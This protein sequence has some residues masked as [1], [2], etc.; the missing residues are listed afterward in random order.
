MNTPLYWT[1]GLHHDGSALY[2][3]SQQP[4]LGDRVTIKLRAPASAPIQ[5]VF[6][7]TAPDG[8]NHL[9][10]MHETWRDDHLAWW[11]VEMP[12]VMPANPY[13]FKLLTAEG[14]YFLNQAGVSRADG[15]EWNDFKLLADYASPAWAQ[16]AVFYQIF[17]DR[18]AAGNPANQVP[19]GAWEIRGYKT[20]RRAWGDPVLTWKETGSL[21]YYG[22]DLPGIVQKIPYLVELGVNALYLNPIFVSYSNHRYDVSDFY[23]I[24]PYVGGN[25]GLA[26]LRRATD[27]AGIKIM[28]DVTLNHLGWR[29]PWFTDAQNNPESA[30]AE[31]F[32][33]YERPEKYES[34]LGVR[35]LPKFNYRSEKLREQMYKSVDSVLRT[36]L[37]PPYRID[38]WRLD[39][40]NM[41]ARQGA[42]Q[43]SHKIGRQLRRAV[44]EEAPNTYLIG[45]HFYDATTYLQGDELDATMNYSGF[46]IPLWRWLNGQDLGTDYRPEV[47]D[48]VLM[49]AEAVVEQW[50]R[51]RAPLPWQVARHQ[52]NLMDSHDTSRIL[53]KLGED[54]TLLP[55]ATAILMTYPGT[56][57]VYYGTE[58]GMTGGPDPDNRRTMP[59]NEAEW[60]HDL[61]AYFKRIIHLR[62]TA[63]ALIDGGYQHLYAEGGLVV[64]QR[65]APSQRLIV[66]GYRGPDALTECHVPVWHSGLNDGAT[67]VDLLG[68]GSYRVENGTLALSNLARGTALILEE[69]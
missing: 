26:E 58:V 4:K 2:V 69:R 36:W 63:P 53:H 21:D 15:P 8:E 44:K 45:E 31:Y 59:W 47:A 27:E 19:E 56:P 64:Y 55:L 33:F 25:E 38:G 23:N 30:T 32:T 48:P 18:F 17:P 65:Q 29:H 46:A 5:R 1:A 66:V 24:D 40:A 13:R 49:P 42:I 20:T 62:R 16:S 50:T 6:L 52:F 10:A 7:R 68:G 39:V 54:K 61:L 12:V 37:R 22:G 60:D 9:E 41:Q 35:S 67:L 11:S 57:S 28:L 3:S 43:L 51:F 14:A 34:W